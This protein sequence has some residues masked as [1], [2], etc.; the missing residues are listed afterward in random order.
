MLTKEQLRNKCVA[1]G[2]RYR[3]VELLDGSEVR[4]QSLTRA[5]QREWRKSTQ[6]KDGTT[7]VRKV[8]YSNDALLA[9]SIVDEQ[10]GAVFTLGDALS[11]MFD[12]WDVRDTT[13]LVDAIVD[14][15]GLIAD[16]KE[17]D[18]ALKNSEET[19]GKDSSG[20][21]APATA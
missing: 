20:V 10:G 5:E 7:D 18:A 11:G 3:V 1:T 4:I 17:I 9:M 6:K 2:R 19:P 21:S 15:C 12:L 14:H 8:E 13:L 16:A